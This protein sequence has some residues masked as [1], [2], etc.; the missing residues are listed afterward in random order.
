MSGL[1]L[2]INIQ[3]IFLHMLNF[4]ILAGGLY[5]ILYKPVRSFM[6][7][8]AAYFKEIDDAAAD[9]KA[10]AESVE[11]QCADML[12]AAEEEA[13]VMKEKALREAEEIVNKAK[14]DAKDESRKIIEDAHAKAVKERQSIVEGAKQD[15]IELVLEAEKKLLQKTGEDND[16]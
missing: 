4:V 10:Q 2:N 14:S 16:K 8:R 5:F 12:H 3:Q 15:I 1:P 6:D 9:K 7:K 11:K 13:R